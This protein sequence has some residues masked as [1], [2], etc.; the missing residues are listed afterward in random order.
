[1]T[2]RWN[3]TCLW[4]YMWALLP[5]AGR[6]FKVSIWAC[7]QAEEYGRYCWSPACPSQF[8]LIGIGSVVDQVKV[9]VQRLMQLVRLW[10]FL[11]A[12]ILWEST[13]LDAFVC[14]SKIT[15]I[16]A[17]GRAFADTTNTSRYFLDE[18][19]SNWFM[20]SSINQKKSKSLRFQRTVFTPKI[21]PN[22][23]Q[24]DPASVRSHG[25]AQIFWKSDSARV[26]SILEFSGI[27]Q[28]L[29]DAPFS[30]RWEPTQFFS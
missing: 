22:G 19:V 24:C 14:R 20:D 7:W 29:F 16:H 12:G 11:H 5:P 15:F 21:E 28:F 27:H 4:Q 10:A 8:R 1:M 3:G 25:F 18:A 23:Q 2:K 26:I 9:S 13:E 17:I 6:T 30:L